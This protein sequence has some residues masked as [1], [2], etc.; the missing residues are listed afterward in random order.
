M[1]VPLYGWA[2]THWLHLAASGAG[3]DPVQGLWN[4]P[5][6]IVTGDGVPGEHL[7]DLVDVTT[8][9]PRAASGT[10]GS[11]HTAFAR[12]GFARGAADPGAPGPGAAGAGA[13]C[14]SGDALPG[15]A[16]RAPAARHRRF[17]FLWAGHLVVLPGR[18]AAGHLVLPGPSPRLATSGRHPAATGESLG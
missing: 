18:C 3:L 8:G 11:T 7:V 4:M 6:N 9:C 2:K 14:E 16:A 17:R 1:L 13:E 5:R 15:D 10:P 12:V